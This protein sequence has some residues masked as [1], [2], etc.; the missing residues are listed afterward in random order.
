MQLDRPRGPG[1]RVAEPGPGP[2]LVYGELVARLAAGPTR[3]YAG[4]KRQLN[5]WLYSR[6]DEQLELEAQIQR[7]MAGSGDFAE[8]LKAFAGKRPPRFTGA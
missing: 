6:M 8:G 7:E 3:S 1:G 5:N 2:D 4:T